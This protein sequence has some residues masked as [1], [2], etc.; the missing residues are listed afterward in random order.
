MVCDPTL[1]RLILEGDTNHRECEKSSRYKKMLVITAGTPTMGTKSTFRGEGWDNSRKAVAASFSNTNLFKVLPELS[2][3]L[4]QFNDVIDS[5]INQ[6]KS[7]DNIVVW[8]VA[9]TIDFLGKSMVNCEFGTLHHHAV[10]N[11]TA[12]K[13][14]GEESVGYELVTKLNNV[15]REFMLLQTLN[16]FRKYQFWNKEVSIAKANTVD[17]QS[18][19]QKILDK[20]RRE[21]TV[22][23]TETDN[24][25][26]GH[27]VKSPYPSDKERV[28]DIT[29]FMIAGHE[30]TA[31]QASW[32][33][34]E[35]SGHP[36]LVA[37]IRAELDALFPVCV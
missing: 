21:H 10:Q 4:N 28:A 13:V 5:H 1:A 2:K 9:L 34:I 36:L 30:T 37:K 8:M 31:N 29:G 19:S 22:E 6:D 7:V 23:Q 16:P 11:G 12:V 14:P 24:S 3:C 26:I 35:L 32:L 17:V 15:I 25:I 18:I 33:I 27:L 20:Y